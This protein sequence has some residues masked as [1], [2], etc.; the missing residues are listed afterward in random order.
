LPYLR[1]FTS[2]YKVLIRDY[3]EAQ[4]DTLYPAQASA[5]K[6]Q[7]YAS[8]NAIITSESAYK[9]KHN[10]ENQDYLLT[11]WRTHFGTLVLYVVYAHCMR[12]PESSGIT[13]MMPGMIPLNTDESLLVDDLRGF[14]VAW[15]HSWLGNGTTD[16]PW[17]TLSAGTVSEVIA[18]DIGISEQAAMI[19]AYGND[20]P[21]PNR[22][23][24]TTSYAI[25]GEN[26]DGSLTSLTDYTYATPDY[27]KFYFNG[28]SAHIAFIDR[29]KDFMNVTGY[30]TQTRYRYK[31]GRQIMNYLAGGND[32]TMVNNP[33][34]WMLSH[35]GQQLMDFF[36]W[37]DISASIVVQ[38][39]D[40]ELVDFTPVGAMAGFGNTFG[41]GF[42]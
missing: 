15:R 17:F 28:G 23:S 13:S 31:I 6:A 20:I 4:I 2:T 35:G 21:Y 39:Q 7:L 12:F 41:E 37:K 11:R 1:E 29:M 32:V 30:T 36:G 33:K 9:T 8:L 18:G 34:A 16:H 25:G 22:F 19:W 27:N 5:M 42:A 38:P 14:S 40:E 10:N 24:N 3:W 26:G